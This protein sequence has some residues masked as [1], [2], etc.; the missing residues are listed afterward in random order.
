V[1]LQFFFAEHD[2]TQTLVLKLWFFLFQ[3]FM[4]ENKGVIKI[5]EILVQICLQGGNFFLLLH[6]A[7]EGRGQQKRGVR[8]I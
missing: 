3:V 8:V 6:P 5:L 7:S 2:G 4:I 1:V